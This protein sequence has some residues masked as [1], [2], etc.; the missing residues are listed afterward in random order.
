MMIGLIGIIMASCT[1]QKQ[2]VY[3]QDMPAG[4]QDTIQDTLLI[5][6]QAGDKVDIRVSARDPE[7]S[8]LFNLY[9]NTTS[10]K[11]SG[12]TLDSHGD[13]MFPILGRIHVAG[14][15][16]E[17]L[18]DFITKELS[19]KQLVKDPVVTVAFN[20]LSVTV[21]GD[22]GSPSRVMIDK[23]YYT[24]LDAMADFGDL[25]I[26]GERRDVKVLRNTNGIIM[27]YEIDLT[28]AQSLYHSPAYFLQQNDVIYIHPNKK[29]TR[30]STD[31]GSI[32]ANPTFWI[33]LVSSTLSL[34]TTTVLLVDRIKK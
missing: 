13:I 9:G 17:E 12:Y 29:S 22:A 10:D 14:M 24:I 27:A 2:V 7:I 18:R 1:M 19:D 21:L 3:F 28:S 23:D 8:S 4:T 25:K 6:L 16:R 26:T 32:A 15:G 20:N 31:N 33:S 5:R 34:T 30:Q 11:E